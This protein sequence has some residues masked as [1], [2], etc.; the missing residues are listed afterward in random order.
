MADQSNLVISDDALYRRFNS[1]QHLNPPTLCGYQQRL[2]HTE[3]KDAGSTAE[4]VRYCLLGLCHGDA[5]M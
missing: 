2:E 5:C 4:A 3:F 1:R